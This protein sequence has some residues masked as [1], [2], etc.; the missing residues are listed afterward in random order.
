[1]RIAAILIPA[2]MLLAQ[3]P[4]VEAP[5]PFQSVGTMSELMLDVIYPTSD[6][7]FYVSR[8]E[9]KTEKDWIALRR[10]ALIL[11]ESAN[12]LMAENRARDKDKWMKDAKL[13]L[14]VGNKAYKAARAKDLP[15]LEALNAELYESCQACHVDYRPGYRRR[16]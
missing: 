9:Q 12:L 4:S 13:L 14:E 16:P 2:A 5:T 3:T 11:A 1:M 15:A 8:D 7:I 10:D 6:Q